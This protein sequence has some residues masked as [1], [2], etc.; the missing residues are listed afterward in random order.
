MHSPFDRLSELSIERPKTAISLS[1]IGILL[2][3][4]CA[5]FIVFDNSEDA[6][7]PDT[8]TTRLMYEIEDAYHRYIAI[9]YEAR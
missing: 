9:D 5:R 7:Y 8:E 1:I 4:S 6:F 3:A 2:L